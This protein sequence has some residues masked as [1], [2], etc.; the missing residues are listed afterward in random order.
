MDDTTQLSS[1]LRGLFGLLLDRQRTL[2]PENT[3]PSELLGLLIGNRGLLDSDT[4]K[5]ND[6]GPEFSEEDA[7]T[8]EIRSHPGFRWLIKNQEAKEGLAIA[9]E[10]SGD[11]SG[12][13]KLTALRELNYWQ[14]IVVFFLGTVAENRSTHTAFS[15]KEKRDIAKSARNLSEQ[16]ALGADRFSTVNSWQLRDSLNRLATDLEQPSKRDYTTPERAKTQSLKRLAQSLI[17]MG[18]KDDTAIVEILR[19]MSESVKV[20]R[21]DRHLQRYVREARKRL[22]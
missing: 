17:P 20:T 7:I 22:I 10:H 12:H 1:D 16:L 18:F 5:Q 15:A 11:L 4:S 9:L 14:S 13:Q 19:V 8:P 6:A 2:E 3:Q 21:S